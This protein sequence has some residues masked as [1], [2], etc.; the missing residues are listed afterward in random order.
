[1]V[2]AKI[3]TP[4]VLLSSCLMMLLHREGDEIM[5]S[6]IA[7]AFLKARTFVAH[8]LKLWQ[9]ECDCWFQFRH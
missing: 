1:M 8:E 6:L 2:V 9:K 3:G 7:L 4:F 5:M